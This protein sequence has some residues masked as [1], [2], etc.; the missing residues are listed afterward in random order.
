MNHA[1]R[2]RTFVCSPCTEGGKKDQADPQHEHAPPPHPYY[3]QRVLTTQGGTAVQWSACCKKCVCNCTVQCREMSV[4]RENENSALPL[5]YINVVKQR[6]AD[7]VF[8]TTKR[9]LCLCSPA[10]KIYDSSRLV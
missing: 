2:R 6:G 7:S 1:A 10:C 9:V 5:L 4:L 8:V 3:A